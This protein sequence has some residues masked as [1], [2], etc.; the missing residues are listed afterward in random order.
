M[1]NLQYL[2]ISDSAFIN[3][4]SVKLLCRFE[5]KQLNIVLNFGLALKHHAKVTEADRATQKLPLFESI[6]CDV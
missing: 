2:G 4:F 6:W 1:I 5:I 3:T